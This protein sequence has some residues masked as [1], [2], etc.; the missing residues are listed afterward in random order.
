ML[1]SRNISI[2]RFTLLTLSVVGNWEL[3]PYLLIKVHKEHKHS[4]A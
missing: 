1:C 4:E 3:R 2:Y